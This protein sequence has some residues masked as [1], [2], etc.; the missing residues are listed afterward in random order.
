MG[1]VR[2][3]SPVV[4]GSPPFAVVSVGVVRAPPASPVCSPPLCRA[5]PAPRGSAAGSSTLSPARSGVAA[6]ES[7]GEPCPGCPSPGCPAAVRLASSGR[8]GV[9]AAAVA[10]CPSAWPCVGGN[11]SSPLTPRRLCRKL[12]ALRGRGGS[13]VRPPPRCRRWGHV[14]LCASAAVGSGPGGSPPPVPVSPCIS[15]KGVQEGSCRL[16]KL[17]FNYFVSS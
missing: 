9:A 14:C 4:P 17:Y 11:H 5:A 8:A 2:R 10:R 12:G 1:S 16:A 15:V 6:A 13:V 7:R 3:P